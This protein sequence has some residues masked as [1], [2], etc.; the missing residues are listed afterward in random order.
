MRERVFSILN[1]KLSESRYVFDLLTV[2]LFIGLA[3]ALINIVAFTLFIYSFS[4]TGLPYAFLSIAV[5]LLALNL[6]YEKLEHKYSPPRLLKVILATSIL[7]LFLFWVGLA[8]ANKHVVIYI[9]LIWSTLF[10]MITGYAFW[11]LVSLLFNIRESKRVFSIVGAGDIPAKFI[12]YLAAPLLIPLIGLNNLLLLSVAS[13]VTG[14]VLLHRLM[15]QKSWEIILRKA[16]IERRHH[17]VV[18]HKKGRIESFFRNELIFSI[19]LLSILSYNV[20]VLVDFTFLAQV[21]SHFQDLTYLATFIAQFFAGGR[22]V[23]LI[24]KLVFSSRAIERLGIITCLS[25]TPV[26]LAAFSLGFFAIDN[27][28]YAIYIFGVMALLTEVLR[29][30]IQEPVFLI[31]F[32]PLSEHLRLKGHIIAKGYMFPVSL[33]IV[34][35]SLIVFP[36]AGVP[37]TIMNTIKILLINLAI[38]AVVIGLIKKAYIKVL[39]YSIRKG[40]FS[41]EEIQAYDKKTIDILLAKVAQGKAGEVI[42]ALKLLEGSGYEQADHLLEGQLHSPHPEVAK[43]A[44]TRLEERGKLQPPLLHGLLATTTAPDVKE[45]IISILCGTDPQFLQAASDRLPAEDYPTRKIIIRHLLNQRE[46]TY[47]FK[48][49]KEIHD[50]I[51]SP[52]PDERA[53]ALDIIGELKNIQFTDAIEALVADPEPSIRHE[54]V[55]VACKLRV[56]KLLPYILSLLDTPAHKYLAMRGLQFYGDALFE[57]LAG[58]GSE[59]VSRHHNDLVKIAGKIKGPHSTSFLLAQLGN[60]TV[61]TERLIHALWLKGFQAELPN[62]ISQLQQLLAFYLKVGVE[63][64]YYCNEVPNLQGQE[65]IKDSILSEIKND[66]ATALKLCAILYHKNEINRILE[67]VEHSTSPKLF[68]AMEMLEWVLPKKISFQINSLIDF[69]LDPTLVKRPFIEYDPQGFLRKVLVTHANAFNA[70]TKAVCIYCSLKNP[71]VDLIR[72]LDTRDGNDPFIMKETR[73]YALQAL[74]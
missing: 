8:V 53:L 11:G 70:W 60:A 44:L 43:Y 12:G 71:Q 64:I 39:H 61:Q 62:D 3:N 23:A 54:A 34:G 72:I 4:I 22:L 2:Q 73:N 57:D 51:S 48:A 24:L 68:N 35:V 58:I 74:Q 41:G 59:E 67:L 17:P 38:W 45:K 37:L 28:N 46:F 66:L 30:T 47:L 29:S 49:G 65:L 21:K 27:P 40:V 31:L 5:F 9:L 13:L 69:V 1:I 42:Y 25:I 7:V 20:F 33:V 63:K 16:N 52:R 50:L 18:E 56:H 26:T 10:Y 55:M 32:Q 15:H 6:V 36:L 19:S 14:F